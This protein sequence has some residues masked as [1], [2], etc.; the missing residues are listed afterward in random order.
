M[1]FVFTLWKTEGL[2]MKSQTLKLTLTLSKQLSPTAVQ[3]YLQAP[4]NFPVQTSNLERN[5]ALPSLKDQTFTYHF[6]AV[7]L[8]GMNC[9]NHIYPW[10]VASFHRL[11]V[12]IQ[13][14][15]TIF[16]IDLILR[17]W[18]WPGFLLDICSSLL[19]KCRKN[20]R[21][22]HMSCEVTDVFTWWT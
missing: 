1:P 22:K 17:R 21:R 3:Q 9:L 8:E 14:F 7:G 11:T 10:N 2:E 4:Y 19:L 6:L 13:V 20:Q 15:W 12:T 16:K 18:S 5:P